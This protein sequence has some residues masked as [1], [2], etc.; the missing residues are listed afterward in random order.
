MPPLARLT[1]GIA[2]VVV[3]SRIDIRDT[4]PDRLV[5]TGLLISLRGFDDAGFRLAYGGGYYERTLA[6][7]LPLPR[8]IGI[9]IGIGYA[10]GRLTSI[11]PQPYDLRPLSSACAASFRCRDR[12]LTTVRK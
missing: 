6:I 9:G 1:Q 8:T 3:L 7:L 12:S 5:P 10:A 4:V 2:H 11:D